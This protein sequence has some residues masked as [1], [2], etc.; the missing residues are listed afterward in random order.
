MDESPQL[1]IVGGVDHEPPL[2]ARDCQPQV[3]RVALHLARVDTK[4]DRFPEGRR[5]PSFILLY[6]CTVTLE[7]VARSGCPEQ[8]YLP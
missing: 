6:I 3:V 1:L 4:T 8:A 7:N 2:F 5:P